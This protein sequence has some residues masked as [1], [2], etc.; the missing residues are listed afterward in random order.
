MGVALRV[1]AVE[2]YSIVSV[3]C[4]LGDEKAIYFWLVTYFYLDLNFIDIFELSSQ[5]FGDWLSIFWGDSFSI[6]LGDYLSA[7]LGDFF[8]IYYSVTLV[9]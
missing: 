4:N 2:N 8:L 5:S 7:L 9:R 1:D 3:C 6:F